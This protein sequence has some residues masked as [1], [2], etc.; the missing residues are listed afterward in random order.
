[1]LF[2]NYGFKEEIPLGVRSQESGVRSQESGV[3]SQESGVRSQESG[4][5]SQESGVRMKNIFLFCFLPYQTL[6]IL[7]ESLQNPL[8]TNVLRL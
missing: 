5:R 3:R 1:M 8:L 4:V 6:C 2:E 7:N